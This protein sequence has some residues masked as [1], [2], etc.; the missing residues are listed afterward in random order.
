MIY[1]PLMDFRERAEEVP[2]IAELDEAGRAIF[3]RVIDATDPKRV[4]EL[5]DKYR[6]ELQDFD[7]IGPF[8]YADLPFWIAHK[9]S[10]ARE[11]GLDRSEPKAILD[12]GMGAGHFAAVCQALGHRVVGTDISV[13]LYDD[14]CAVLEV[15]RRIEPTRHRTPLPNLGLKFDLVTVIWQV[16][17]VLAVFPNG[18]R[19]HWS[20][21]DW[22][23]FLSDLVSNH[24]NFPG[25][26]YLYLNTNVSSTG[27][28]FDPLFF[29]WCRGEGASV[30]DIQGKVLFNPIDG[31]SGPRLVAMLSGV[32]VEKNLLASHETIQAMRA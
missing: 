25:T 2:A 30:D 24:L 1:K 13:P 8:K 21:E 18:D 26:I 17:H 22:E 4:A 7:P 3:R 12:I 29:Q 31:P 15:D 16:F 23:F 10:T 28:A 11:L 20:I 6:K 32:A 27:E 14:I 9:V 5:Q 19:E